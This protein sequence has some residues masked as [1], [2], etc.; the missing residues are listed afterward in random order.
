MSRLAMLARGSV[1]DQ[2]TNA[3]S[4]GFTMRRL[5][6][7]HLSDSSSRDPRRSVHYERDE[8]DGFGSIRLGTPTMVEPKRKRP[9]FLSNPS[10]D[11]SGPLQRST[12]MPNVRPTPAARMGYMPPGAGRIERSS[13]SRLEKASNDDLMSPELF[14]KVETLFDKMDVN[15]D[16]TVDRD[17]AAHHFKRFSEVSAKAMFNEVDDD[18]NNF[19]TK[20]EFLDFWSQVKRS[21]YSE[22]DLNYE[23]DELLRG[24][25]WVDYADSRDVGGG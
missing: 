2:S 10:L 6:L 19:I 21:G 4:E 9:H 17:E 18:G 7:D 13:S 8:D 24:N 20:Q 25:V 23:I 3:G 15:H 11:A 22:E 1:F 14:A 5:P 16:G 12:S